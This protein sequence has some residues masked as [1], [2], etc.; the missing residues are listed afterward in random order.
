MAGMAFKT[1]KGTF[2]HSL[3]SNWEQLEPLVL[4]DLTGDVDIE[5]ATPRSG[6]SEIVE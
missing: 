2:V 6:L 4:R 5:I 3:P 1:T